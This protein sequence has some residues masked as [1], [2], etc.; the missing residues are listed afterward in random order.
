MGKIKYK[1]VTD[2][3]AKIA[4]PGGD[5]GSRKSIGTN[6]MIEEV[7]YINSPA[8][9]PSGSGSDKLEPDLSAVYQ[10]I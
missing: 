2:S 3:L 1:E 7:F 4:V 10:P 5:F 9:G 6:D 8:D